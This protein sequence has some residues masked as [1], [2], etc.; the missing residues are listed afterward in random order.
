MRAAAGA[1]D[2]LATLAGNNWHMEESFRMAGNCVETARHVEALNQQLNA[3]FS[4]R[5]AI[6]T[7]VLV[8]RVMAHAAVICLRRTPDTSMKRTPGF[9][10]LIPELR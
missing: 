7:Q 5:N 8:S 4:T 3:M 9:L 1:A 10:P 2:A 6:Q